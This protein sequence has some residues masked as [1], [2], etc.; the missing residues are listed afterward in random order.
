MEVRD[1]LSPFRPGIHHNPIA[2]VQSFLLSDAAY[3]EEQLSGELRIL[4]LQ[5]CQRSYGL[6][7]DHE[8]VHGSRGVDV[9][10][11]DDVLI[12]ID[13]GTGDFAIDDPAED[14]LVCHVSR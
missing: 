2:G 14:R 3:R 12:L 7:G 9:A 6:P 4:F 1:R 8:D 5:M 10:Y 13:E 11:G